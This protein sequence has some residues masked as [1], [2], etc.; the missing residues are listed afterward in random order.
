MLIRL[1]IALLPLINDTVMSQRCKQVVIRLLI[2][3]ISDTMLLNRG[4][5]RS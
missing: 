5:N 2:A 1:L 4:V 3:L